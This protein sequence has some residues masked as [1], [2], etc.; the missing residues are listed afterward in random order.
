MKWWT[1]EFLLVTIIAACGHKEGLQCSGVASVHDGGGVSMKDA[2]P[3]R[4]PAQSCPTQKMTAFT[5]QTGCHND[6]NVEFCIPNHDAALLSTIQAIAASVK[7]TSGGG[8][9]RCNPSTELLCFYP[10]SLGNCLARYGELT[11]AAW[12]QLCQI[13]ALPQVRE[14]VPTWFE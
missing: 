4:S 6:G 1:A 11:D 9:A 12:I 5:K 8:R 7:C 2:P 10:T 13:A 14:I 3:A